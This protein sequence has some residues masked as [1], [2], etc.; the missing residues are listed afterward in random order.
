MDVLY[1]TLE[2]HSFFIMGAGM[3]HEDFIYRIGINNKLKHLNLAL[4][5]S[6]PAIGQQSTI[7]Y[8]HRSKIIIGTP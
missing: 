1:V 8:F 2:L 5:D 7:V 4:D 3:F 6:D